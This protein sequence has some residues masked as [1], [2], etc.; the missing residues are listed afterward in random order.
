MFFAFGLLMQFANADTKHKLEEKEIQLGTD[1]TGLID[2]SVF[3]RIAE[4]EGGVSLRF[5]GYIIAIEKA[6]PTAIGFNGV[7]E[8][9]Y[10]EKIAGNIEYTNSVNRILN[11]APEAEWKD[12]KTKCD[13]IESCWK[14]L[15]P[16]IRDFQNITYFTS[17]T[18][19]SFLEKTTSWLIDTFQLSLKETSNLVSQINHSLSKK[20]FLSHVVAYEIKN[21]K[22]EFPYVAEEFIFNAYDKKSDTNDVYTKGLESLKTLKK[23]IVSDCANKKEYTHIFVYCIGWNTDQQESTRNYNSLMWQ[24]INEYKGK[25]PFKP[26]FI[27]ITWPS[28]WKSEFAGDIVEGLSY[29]NKADD[30][31]EVGLTWVNKIL[32]DV[33]VPLKKEKHI[34]LILVGH[35]FGARV[36]T[37]AVFSSG[38]IDLVKQNEQEQPDQ[39]DSYDSSDIELVIGLEGA[40][41]ID[42]F[43]TDEMKA[44]IPSEKNIAFYDKGAPYSDFKNHAK[45]FIFTWSLHDKAN[46]LAKMV[47][48]ENL[49]GGEPG[50]KISSEFPEVFD[51]FVVKTKETKESWDVQFVEVSKKDNGNEKQSWTNSFRNQQRISIVDASN[52]I[53]NKVYDKGGTAHSDVYTPGVAQFVWDCINNIMPVK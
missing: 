15:E 9:F 30:A 2:L 44:Q 21:D 12:V 8:K 1:G 19:N 28:L 46:P 23:K 33:V 26:L 7:E 48:K 43:I 51:Q 50:Y 35:S 18:R 11:R 29:W 53:K 49:I 42:R 4:K 47:T 3:H 24:L 38:I 45:K 22:G 36:I 10:K 32:Q 39:S 31:D 40:F 20:M 13:N 34:P 37:R 16:R 6:Y 27:G 25:E 14:L 5:P 17:F 52:L 41:G